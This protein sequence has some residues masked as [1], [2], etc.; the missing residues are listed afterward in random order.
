MRVIGETIARLNIDRFRKL[1][2]TETDPD[3]R[4]TL[5]DLIREEERKL[6]L[7]GTARRE[8]G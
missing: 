2:L 3:K 4:Q 1:L 8:P 7:A 6:R 5:A